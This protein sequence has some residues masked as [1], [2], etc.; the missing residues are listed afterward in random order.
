M[1]RHDVLG[2]DNSSQLQTIAV[3]PSYG[4][5]NIIEESSRSELMP[6]A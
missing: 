5:D 1:T 6:E 2:I 4:E 3:V